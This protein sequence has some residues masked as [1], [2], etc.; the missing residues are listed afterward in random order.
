MLFKEDLVELLGARP[1][2]PKEEPAPAEEAVAEAPATADN[3]SDS[4]AA[5]P[6]DA[7]EEAAPDAPAEDADRTDENAA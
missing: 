4:A 5:E 1:W 3:E 6:T 2:D 7:T